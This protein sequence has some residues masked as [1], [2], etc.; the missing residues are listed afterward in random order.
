MPF[1][2]TTKGRS[3]IARPMPAARPATTPIRTLRRGSWG[4][5]RWTSA[6]CTRPAYAAGRASL[7]HPAVAFG[8]VRLLPTRTIMG[9]TLGAFL[10]D[11][12]ARTPTREAIA[13]APRDTVIARLTFAEL[14]A[15][16]RR[17]AEAL[18]GAGVA[19]GTRV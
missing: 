1:S 11:V 2:L 17:A 19:H 18:H 13:Y 6:T 9:E 5:G 12:A 10:D 3:T 7:N 16:S 4:A 15:R 14:A 8:A